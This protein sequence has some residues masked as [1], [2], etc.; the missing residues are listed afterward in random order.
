LSVI[1][2]DSELG[3]VAEICLLGAGGKLH[4]V[5]DD[6]ALAERVVALAERCKSGSNAGLVGIG[7]FLGSLADKNRTSSK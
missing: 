2:P 7:Y 5:K 4:N 3:L 1:E 6:H